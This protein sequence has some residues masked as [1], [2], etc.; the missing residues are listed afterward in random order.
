[1]NLK[2]QTYPGSDG[3]KTKGWPSWTTPVLRWAKQQ[4]GVTGYAHSASGLEI[5]A[6]PASKRLLKR[7]DAN[8]DGLLT[9]TECQEALLPLPFEATDTDGDQV[10]T[11]AELAAAHDRAAEQLPNLAVPEMNGVGAMEIAVSVAAGVCDF[12]SA[13]DTPRIAEWNMWYHLLNCGF[14]LKVSGETDFPCMSGER[15]G[16]G[17]VYVQLGKPERLDFTQWC[18]GLARGRSYVSDGFAHA[19]DFQVDDGRLGFGDV[20]RSG[21]GK[22]KIHA[23]VAFAPETPKTI[24]QGLFVPPDGKRFVGDTVTLH[25]SSREEHVSGGMRLVEVIINGVA[26]ASQ[27]V[28]ADGRLHE[29]S[30]QVDCAESCWIAIRSFPQLHTNPINVLVGDQPIRASRSSALWCIES[31]EQLWRSR[32]QKI[33]PSE[34]A[35]AREAFDEA[36]AKF[37]AIASAAKR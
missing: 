7:F 36:V 32:E 29:L 15:V 5:S 28:S 30:F 14:P 8:T 9:V 1:L 26:A 25:G 27:E 23:K 34:R 31:I 17:R 6:K 19:F 4:G 37:R 20:R 22:V 10:L 33:S 3:T 13:M 18:E 16:Q 2:D 35:A 24:A 21:P 11:E 12:I